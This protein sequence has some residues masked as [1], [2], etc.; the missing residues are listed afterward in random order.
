MT[1]H[2]IDKNSYGAG[3]QGNCRDANDHITLD[4]FVSRI[5]LPH[6]KMRKRSW[7]IDERISRRI[8]SP[9]FGTRILAQIRRDEIENWLQGLL[10][11]G[12]AP[13][14]CNRYLAVFKTICA[15]A[16][17]RGFLEKRQSPC[18]RIPSFKIHILR[19]RYLSRHEARLL[20]DAL[21][22]SRRIEALAL[23]LLLLT[24][25]RK[26]EIL[27]ARW[28]NVDLEQRTLR[29]PLSKSGK[30]RY[31]VLSQAAIGVI[32]SI[33]R[34]PGNPWLFPGQSPNKPVSDIFLYWSKVR[35]ELGMSDVRIHDLRHTFASFL[36]NAGHSLYEVQQML[37]HG[38]PR[39]TMRYSHLGQDSLLAAAETVGGFFSNRG[40]TVERARHAAS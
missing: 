37:G 25:A 12:L 2:K 7:Q 15:L 5:Y 18:A 31:I 4:S 24:G 35:R 13:A 36:V 6:I 29:V 14:S 9:L 1:G 28:E 23:R 17:D 11:R 19:E 10:E 32:K 8:L 40:Q 33:P 21:E 22:K 38:D 30:P 3:A 16:E 26:S 20:M 27:K 39:T 34:I